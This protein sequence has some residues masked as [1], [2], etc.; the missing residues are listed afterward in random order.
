MKRK[1][2]I[3]L[4]LIALGVYF[5]VQG[6]YLNPVPV[7]ETNQDVWQKISNFFNNNPMWNP[8]IKFF[9]GT[10]IEPPPEPS[11]TPMIISIAIGAFLIVAATFLTLYRPKKKS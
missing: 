10:P 3:P 2:L 6:I 5:I 11:K 9:G 8:L 7:D 4:L 1:L